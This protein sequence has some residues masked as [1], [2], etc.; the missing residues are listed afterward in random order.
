MS[1]RPTFGL[2]LMSG[3][4]SIGVFAGGSDSEA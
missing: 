3:T 2:K 1:I 4:S